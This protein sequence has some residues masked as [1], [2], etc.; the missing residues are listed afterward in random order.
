MSLIPR[1][2]NS[3]IWRSPFYE[4]EK[5][6][7]EMNRFFEPAVSSNAGVD[8]SLLDGFWSPCVDVID[9]KEAIVVKADLP[10]LTKEDISVSIDNNVLTI[11][12][13]KKHEH[14]EKDGDVV[15]SE[16]YYG[17]FH[18]AFTLPSSVDPEKVNA[19]FENGVLELA[20]TKKEEAK[21][22]Q[23]RIDVK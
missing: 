4:L 17:G 23:I 13:E 18:R 1:N 20:L 2:Q 16:R 9:R 14:E 15:R 5:I 11:S 8:G 3:I 12:G 21:P 6:H 22:R 10:G 7:R 19:K